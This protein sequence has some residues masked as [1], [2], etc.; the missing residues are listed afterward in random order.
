MKVKIEIEVSQK[1][2]D[3]LSRAAQNLKMTR[4]RF[5][6]TPIK[7]MAESNQQ[8]GEEI[9]ASLNKFFAD[10]PDLNNIHAQRYWE[11]K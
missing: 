1:L 5:V 7:R 2:Y 8:S 9:T 11:T 10:H 6:R 4:K 3:D